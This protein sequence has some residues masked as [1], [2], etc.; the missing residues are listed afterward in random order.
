MGTLWTGRTRWLT[1]LLGCVN[2]VLRVSRPSFLWVWHVL[3]STVVRQVGLLLENISAS[4]FSLN[5]TKNM[6]T[7]DLIITDGVSLV[8][9][10]TLLQ[11]GLYSRHQTVVRQSGGGFVRTHV[12]RMD[13]GRW[14][15]T[16]TCGYADQLQWITCHWFQAQGSASSITWGSCTWWLV[17]TRI[18]SVKSWGHGP[19][20]ICHEFQWIIGGWHS[21]QVVSGW[22]HWIQVTMWV[23]NPFFYTEM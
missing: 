18:G 1:L 16:T 20:K 7:W 14:H 10:N 4:P 23:T 2:F 5:L 3:R 17:D 19:L 8:S 9:G 15:I 12:P 6:H 21:I 22:W 11:R 13:A